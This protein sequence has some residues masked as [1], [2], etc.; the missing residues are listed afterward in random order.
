MIS[1]NSN[2]GYDKYHRKKPIKD[3]DLNQTMYSLVTSESKDDLA[4]KATGFMGNDMSYNDLIISADKLAQA[5]HNIGIKDGENVAI[6]TISMPIVQQSLLSLSK[7]GATMSWI[8]LR[9]KPKDVLRYINSGNCKTIIVFEDMLPLIESII[10]ETDVKKVVVSSPKDYLSPIIKVLAMLKDKKDGKKIVLPNDPRF[11]RFNDFIKNVDT[12][13]LI[14]PVSF[15]KDR[16]SLIV[17]SS[18]S[19]GKPKQI[20]HT[21]YN[22]NSAVQK[23]AYTDLPFYKGN[24]MHI[25]IPPFIIYGLGNSIYASM[26]FTMKA[27]MNPFVDENTVY[28]DLGK[29]DISL[30]APLHYRYMY[31]QLIELNKSITELEKDNSL[32]AKKELKQKMK[33]LKRVLTGIDRAKVFVSG[34]DKIGADELI[35][36]QQTFNKVIV[37]GYGNN[38]CLGATIVSPMYANKPGSIGVPMEGIEVKVVNPETE[39]ILPQGEIGE[40]YISSDNLFVEYLNNPDET[41]KIKVIDELEKQ[42]VKSGDLC[43]IDKDGY[44]I[45]RGRNRRL[46]RK[47]AFKISPDTIEEVISSIPFVQD[48]VVVGVDDEK[49]LSV[50]MAFIVLKDETLSF[51]EVKDQIKEK[52]VEELPDYEVPTYFE[53]IE[54]VPYTPNDKQDFRALEELGNSIVRN[55]AAKKLVKK[56]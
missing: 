35:E 50:P 1:N 34:G 23:M 2:F 32:E 15:E 14:T 39:E 51:D 8:D 25:S 21:E 43:Y 36:M 30:A 12:N 42:W 3:F 33:E 11:V 26:A 41:N 55:K 27:E 22:F 44:I 28:N 24:T 38:E 47:E 52:C 16:P 29:F 45:P 17:Q 37:N 48:C 56:K 49:S 10:D 54:K 6:L 4:L 31:K 13:N 53:Q 5:F 18:G 20:V 46:I 19:T 9:S 7:I 40:L